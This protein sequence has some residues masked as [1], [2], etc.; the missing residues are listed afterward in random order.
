MTNET[1]AREA[2]TELLRASEALCAVLADENR[3]LTD[4]QADRVRSGLDGKQQAVAAYER[5]FKQFAECAA[6]ALG[7]MDDSGRRRLNVTAAKLGSLM[8]ENALRLKAA[9]EGQRR[10]IDRIV[11]AVKS[12]T[13]GTGTY[14]GKGTVG[15]KTARMT[16][17]PVSMTFSQS[18]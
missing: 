3:S 10:F 11:D 14:S 2:V 7:G 5:A 4:H 8:N 12:S 9:Q 15:A 1:Q 17:S 16:S 18:L 13:P 6:K